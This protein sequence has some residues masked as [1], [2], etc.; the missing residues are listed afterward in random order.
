MATAASMNPGMAT[1]AQIGPPIVSPAGASAGPAASGGN[2]AI[3][4]KVA[5]P[6]PPAANVAQAAAAAAAQNGTQG[7]AREIKV[8]ITAVEVG[9]QAA[10][11]SAGGGGSSRG[12]ITKRRKP[13]QLN[14]RTVMLTEEEKSIYELTLSGQGRAQ[15]KAS[16]PAAVPQAPLQSVS[17]TAAAAGPAHAKPSNGRYGRYLR[18]LPSSSQPT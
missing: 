12:G 4:V 6:M 10:A 8:H 1:I 11:Q 15:L 18:L 14:G 3:P 2:S 16:L 5:L 13:Y 7:A 9:E 17:A